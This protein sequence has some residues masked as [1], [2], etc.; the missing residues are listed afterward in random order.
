MKKTKIFLCAA[1]CL[2][3]AFFS[4]CGGT[5]PDS[6]TD[7]SSQPQSSS[8][9]GGDVASSDSFNSSDGAATYCNVYPVEYAEV[10]RQTDMEAFYAETKLGSGASNDGPLAY[11]FVEGVWHSLRVA[12]KEVPV[13]SARCGYDVHSFAWVDVETDGAFSLDV[14]LELLADAKGKESVVVLPEK[15]GVQASL[16][17]GIVSAEIEAYG[18]YSF[19]FDEEAKQALTL[20]VAPKAELVVPDGWQTK[21]FEPKRYTR[22]ETNFT[23]GNT[24]YYFKRGA[25]D[26]TSISLPSDS[27]LYFESGTSL[28]IYE[29]GTNDYFAAVSASDVQNVKISGRALLDFS[30]CMGGDGKTKG[31][32]SFS[33]TDGLKIEGLIS[34]NSNNWT[35]CFNNSK[36]A[37][38][39]RCMFFSYRTYSDGVMFSDCKNS[40]ARDCFVRTGDDAMEVKAFT[41][42]TDSDCYTDGLLF[43]NNCV[44]TDKGIGYGCIYESK[45]D[46]KNVIFRNNSI[47]FAQASWSEHLG[48][49]TVQMGSVK[50]S[51]WEDIHFEDME[52]YKTSCA[53]LSV[54]NRANDET[55][56]GKIKDVYFRDI[57][58][59]YAVQTNLPVYCLSVVIRLKEGAS[60]QNSTIGALYLDNIRYA[61]TEITAENYEEYT[62]IALDDGAR[63]ARSS[64]KVNKLPREE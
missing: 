9:G 15:S 64:I 35:M 48:C 46:I 32:Y 39:S 23:E 6:P 53:L 17:D 21:L 31:A 19:A 11:G 30:A 52:V 42:S 5:Q 43:E 58:A 49:C 18:S 24:L 20:Y 3:F 27:I 2:L 28:R 22:E 50:T 38:V 61:G 14:R 8:S 55:E 40:I 7:A 29:Q 62:N 57:T 56:G 16:T 63:F 51:T 41:D 33:Q 26:V 59:K 47:G 4:A 13:Y 34:V 36:N 60:W 54:F 45:H 1:L 25:Y 44:W 10:N 37:E 12:G